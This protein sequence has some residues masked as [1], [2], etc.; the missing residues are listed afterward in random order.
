MNVYYN[1]DAW[2]NFLQIAPDVRTVMV[3]LKEQGFDGYWQ[4]TLRPRLE[5]DLSRVRESVEK[6]NIVPEVESVVGFGLPSGEV[7]VSLVYFEWPYGHHILG[8]HF[9]TIPEDNGVIRS[10]TH[11]LL[12]HP[13]NN[14]DPAFWK[15]ANS[16]KKDA[17]LM[18]AYDD[19]D[20]KYG[21][22]DW[23]Y[24]VAERLV[25]ALEQIIEVKMGLGER[26]TW[27][28]DGGMHLLAACLYQ[29]MQQEGFP[30]NGESY[31]A[32]FIRMVEA[33][34]LQEIAQKTMK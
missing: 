21:Y 14:T 30:Q 7:T 26:W 19:R 29:L 18:A 22:N 32:F 12:H 34:K 15:A 23:P 17:V 33:G 27:Q 28:E 1:E 9:S 10:T 3:F 4:E 31:Q 24:Y 25:R 11:E 6:Y 5:S 2:K 13:F 16:L 8:T 20:P